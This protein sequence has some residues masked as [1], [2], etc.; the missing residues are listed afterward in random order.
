MAIRK[1]T[2]VAIAAKDSPGIS[3]HNI[4]P[5]FAPQT[6]TSD[7]S[8]P[9]NIE[10]HTWANYFAAAYKGTCELLD[11]KKIGNMP[12]GLNVMVHGEVPLGSGLSSSAA[13]VVSSALACLLA[14][15]AHTQVTKSE[16][17]EFT[18]TCE[19]Y[20][21]TLGGGMDQAI[22]VMGNRGGATHI[23]FNPI[24]IDNVSLPSD[25]VFVIANS[26]TPSMKAETAAMRYNMR[27]MEC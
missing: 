20:V 27:V 23:D 22:S 10:N 19:R 2:I 24:S 26:L 8:Q 7:A 18:C 16:L 25:A 5:S 12:P 14:A 15:D 21:G 3:L 1:D 17:A 6:L 13:L 11:Q 4:D 9:V